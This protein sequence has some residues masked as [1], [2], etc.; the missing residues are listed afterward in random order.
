MLVLVR[1]STVS[2]PAPRFALTRDSIALWRALLIFG[3]GI[4]P[5]PKRRNSSAV[6]LPALVPNEA[7]K[8]IRK[9]QREPSK[10]PTSYGEA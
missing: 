7:I 10:E 4:K 3:S 6:V 1:R 9:V 5:R 8:T 2:L